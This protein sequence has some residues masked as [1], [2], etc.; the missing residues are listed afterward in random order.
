[1]R[2]TAPGTRG[3]VGLPVLDSDE[4]AGS[5]E[6]VRLLVNGIEVPRASLG[7]AALGG[8]VRLRGSLP[9]THAFTPE[10]AAGEHLVRGEYACSGGIRGGGG[11]GGGGGGESS[12]GPTFP[13]E[14]WQAVSWSIDTQTHGN[15]I[16]ARGADG[17]VLIGFDVNSTD[18]EPVTVQ[19]LPS[20]VTSAAVDIGLWETVTVSSLGANDTD[21]AFLQ[22]PRNAV[23]SSNGG[24]GGGGSGG[25][26]AAPARRLGFASSGGDGSQGIVVDVN[27]SAPGALQPAALRTLSFYVSSRSQPT[28]AVDAFQTGGPS[29]VARVMD[30]RTLNP[31][32]PSIRFDN[33]GDGTWFSVTICCGACAAGGAS[34]NVASWC[35]VRLRLMQVDGTNTVSAVVFDSAPAAPPAAAAAEAS[36]ATAAIAI[37]ATLGALLSVGALALALRRSGLLGEEAEAEGAG[38]ARFESLNS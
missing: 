12:G 10:L 20:Y 11:G 7:A 29:M 37:G 3:V 17:F 15:W 24:D 13:P 23:N 18:D 8:A 32:T 2:I 21:V 31:I 25:G 14:V 30:L 19:S 26:G 1:V 34:S 28:S 33:F 9:H 6:L 38:G 36:M 4:D 27:M 5:C 16:G 22:D 35:G